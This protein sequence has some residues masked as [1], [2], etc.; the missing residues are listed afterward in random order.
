[1]NL[2]RFGR[3]TPLLRHGDAF[4]QDLVATIGPNGRHTINVNI[5]PRFV[6]G[7]GGQFPPMFAIEGRHGGQALLDID[8]SRPWREQVGL[9]RFADILPSHR[10]HES[11]TSPN[12]EEAQ[13][14]E[15]RPTPTVSRWQEEARILFGSK[16]HEKATRVISSILRLLVPAAMEAKR[17]QDKADA[18][19]KAAEDKAKE[20]EQKRLEAEKAERDAREAREREE[21]EAREAEEALARAQA[22]QETAAADNSAATG[23][24]STSMEG[25]EQSQPAQSSEPARQEQ[26]QAEEPPAERI[27]TTIRGREVDITSLGIDM[28]FL[29]SIPEELREEVIMGQIA[30]QRSQAVQAGEQP[31]EISREFL[32]ALPAEIQR[33]LLR[34]EAIDRRRREQEETRRRATQ[35]GGAAPAQPE[36]MNNADFMAM[37]DPQLRQAILM[38]QDETTLATLPEH[39]QA[40]ARNLLGERR[41]PRPD[42]VPRIGR[43][44]DPNDPRILA[45]EAA[46]SDHAVREGSRQ[47]RPIIQ[48]LDKAGIATLLRLM[49]VSLHHKAKSNLHSIL[50]DVCKNTQNRAEVISILLS[51]LQDGTADVTAVERSFAAL[52]LRAKQ[53]SGPKTPQ[54]L[55]RTAT[56]TLITPG[57]EL[58]PLNIVQQCLG[59]L[60]ALTMDNGR[61]P[62]FFLTEHETI[63][64]QKVKSAKKGKEREVKA[65]KFPLNALL[66][67]L[68][69]KLITENTGVMETLATLL[70]R[71]THPLQILYRRAKE[72]E[73]AEKAEAAK[74]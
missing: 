48:M 68:D 61:V 64:S 65:A 66:T 63:T 30:E 41:L 25:V 59:T 38:D 67:L 43:F 40:E 2:P 45:R 5:E 35:E 34:Q 12:S 17:Q 55:K 4:I 31:S 19:R 24:E 33:E 21:R 53:Q 29:E 56:G 39:I 50:S 13:A 15:F 23:D 60:N 37:L 1:M 3:R 69:R 58:S 6:G 62:S 54:P 8:P 27:T 20:E 10:S 57:A 73:E 71:V 51:I 14:V 26:Q 18:E 32:E 16:Y 72:A 44:A 11:R 7:L 74:K 42:Q 49:F 46:R 52:S 36:E 9:P 28:E 22:E 47:R 70:N